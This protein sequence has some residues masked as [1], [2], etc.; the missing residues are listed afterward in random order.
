MTSRT[1]SVPPHPGTQGRRAITPVAT[2][3]TGEPAGSPSPRAAPPWGQENLD[4]AQSEGDAQRPSAESERPA[5]RDLDPW[6]TRINNV[7]QLTLAV[8]IRWLLKDIHLIASGTRT[9]ADVIFSHRE[10]P[11][12]PTPT[13]GN[14]S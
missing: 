8:R 10:G 3:A 11:N 12:A 5:A 14:P 9:M 13:S 6:I 4:Y 7:E 1:P 2:T